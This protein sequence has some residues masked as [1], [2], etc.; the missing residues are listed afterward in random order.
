MDNW[1][2]ADTSGKYE[3]ST[4]TTKDPSTEHYWMPR[5]LD[6][7]VFRNIYDIQPQN[8]EQLISIPGFGPAS[9]RALSDR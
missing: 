6:W 2:T 5:R 3:V 9:I 8:Y 1:I 4:N 7:D